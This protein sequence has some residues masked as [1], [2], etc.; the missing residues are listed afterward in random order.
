[1]KY[2]ILAGG[3][4]TRWNHYQGSDKCLLKIGG[5]ALIDRTVRLLLHYGVTRED[6]IICPNDEVFQTIMADGAL[7]E[8]TCA[9]FEL[10][11]AKSK[12]EAFEM[13]AN[14]AKEPFSVLFGDVF[15]TEAIIKD[16]I[17]RPVKKWAHWFN[18]NPNKYTGKPWSEGYCHKV[19]D[20]EWWFTK[21]HEFNQLVETGVIQAGRDYAING[22]LEER[23]MSMVYFHDFSY[24]SDV[25][26]YWNDW[27]DDFDFPVDYDRFIERYPNYESPILSVVIPFYNANHL[28]K[29]LIIKLRGLVE[30]SGKNI[31]IVVV[32]DGSKEDTTWLN[33]VAELV[34]I[35]KPNGNP[36]SARNVGMRAATGKYITFVDADDEVLD[37]FISA[38]TSAIETH[39]ENVLSFKATCEDGSNMHHKGTVWGKAYLKDF[40]MDVPFDETLNGGEDGRWNKHVRE[41]DGFSVAF[42]DTT[43]YYYHWSANP[44]SLCKRINRGEL[45]KEKQDV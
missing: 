30:A 26:V 42:I 9:R 14:I 33:K 43:I 20:W 28:L 25:D 31:E 2:F 4:G 7:H 44:D 39:T 45:P 27:T 41:K 18:P 19:M 36:A 15:Y 29:N 1:M 11:S 17:D 34:V 22:Y 5:E 8:A 13:I 10:L 16:I 35:H 38:I 24:M 37:N 3:S 23:P 21:M 40:I 12:G 6:I 32:D